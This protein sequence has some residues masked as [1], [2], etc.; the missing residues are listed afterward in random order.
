MRGKSTI[1]NTQQNNSHN[2]RDVVFFSEPRD[3][4]QLPMAVAKVW[5]FSTVAEM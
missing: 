5:G 4:A 1:K 2:I 3:L